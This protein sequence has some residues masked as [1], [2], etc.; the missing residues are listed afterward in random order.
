LATLFTAVGLIPIGTQG[1]IVTVKGI[2][3][4]I[5]EYYASEAIRLML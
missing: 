1:L 4:L 3:R 2:V 5:V